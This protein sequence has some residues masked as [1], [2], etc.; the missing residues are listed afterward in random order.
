MATTV[1]ETNHGSAKKVVWS[2]VSDGSG[3][4]SLITTG[5]YDG[6]ILGLTTIP[7]GGG[8]APTDNYDVT[9]LDRDSHDVLLGWG[10]KKMLRASS[11]TDTPS[12][13]ATSV[14]Y[15]WIS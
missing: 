2:W 6:E 3:D 11:V 14:S 15:A 10:S 5:V 7:S 4:A 1:A 12:A 8:T 13:G 9:I